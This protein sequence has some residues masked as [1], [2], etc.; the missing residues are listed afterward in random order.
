V[1]QA[2]IAAPDRVE[3][4]GATPGQVGTRAASLAI[5]VYESTAE[6]PSLKEAFFRLTSAG[7]ARRAQ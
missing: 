7:Q 3:V 2:R 6:A 5:P 4:T 1:A